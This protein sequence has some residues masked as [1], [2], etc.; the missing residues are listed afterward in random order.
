VA[1]IVMIV[2]VLTARVALLMADGRSI[3]DRWMILLAG[4][5]A[6]VEMADGG[7]IDD[8]EETGRD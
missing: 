6:S 2:V 5:L 1:S 7:P 8:L 4:E 3:D